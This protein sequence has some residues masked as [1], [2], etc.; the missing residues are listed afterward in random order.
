[1]SWAHRPLA[2]T[3]RAVDRHRSL[4]RSVS[5]SLSGLP[6]MYAAKL[7]PLASRPQD[8]EVSPI[9]SEP[10]ARLPLA[11]EAPLRPSGLARVLRLSVYNRWIT[12]VLSVC[13]DGTSV[14][15]SAA[16]NVS[17]TLRP[18]RVQRLG[19][20]EALA[21]GQDHLSPL[22]PEHLTKGL[23]SRGAR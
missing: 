9:G 15:A 23:G 20:A 12:G 17:Q 11:G 2:G 4:V 18:L 13:A 6:S 7:T 8:G 10:L 3:V 22:L 19:E 16:G 21:S 5:C 14:R 1:M